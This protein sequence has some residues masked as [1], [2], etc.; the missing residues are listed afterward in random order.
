MKPDHL[1]IEIGGE[2]EVIKDISIIEIIF[3]LSKF[4][5]PG[6]RIVR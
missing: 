4:N 6:Q 5:V 1:K 2:E 3:A